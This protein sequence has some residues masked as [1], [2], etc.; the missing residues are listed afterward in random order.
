LLLTA[1]LDGEDW[2]E[3]PT[4]IKAR[5]KANGNFKLKKKLQRKGQNF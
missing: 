4:G 3:A 5:I 2:W 1:A